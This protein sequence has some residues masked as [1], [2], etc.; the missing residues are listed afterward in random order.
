MS[1]NTITRIIGAIAAAAIVASYL[2]FHPTINFFKISPAWM[3]VAGVAAA[4]AIVAFIITPYITIIPFLWVRDKIRKA[5]AS[6][7]VSAAIGLTIGLIIS[8]LLA[9]PLAYLPDIFGR[10]LPFVAAVIFGYLGMTTAVVR[11]SD[12]AHLFQSTIMRRRER[13]EERER[14]RGKERDKEA[15]SAAAPA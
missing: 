15:A 14:D 7:L 6:D 8:A 12:I 11:K 1:A 4:A 5:A 13:D 3:W 9:I 10:L 2:L